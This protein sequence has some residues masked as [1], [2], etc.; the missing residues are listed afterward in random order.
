MTALTNLFD[1]ARAD[2]TVI[3]TPLT[4]LSELDF[5]EIQAEAREVLSLLDQGD[6]KNVV[7]DFHHTD[8]CG[9]TALGFF[10]T[11]WKRLRQRKGQLVFCNLSEHESEILRITQLSGL[12]PIYTSREEAL[13]SVQSADK[14]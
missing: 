8:Y 11:L 2:D 4:N 3:V 9:S 12:W 14:P 1:V 10:V 7:M 13:K 5:Q 6:V